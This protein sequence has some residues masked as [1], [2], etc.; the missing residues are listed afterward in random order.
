MSALVH[1][2]VQWVGC[3]CIHVC[4]MRTRPCLAILNWEEIVQV[5][6]SVMQLHITALCRI[7][8]LLAVPRA[9]AMVCDNAAAT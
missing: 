5:G 3:K 8:L 2:L 1:Q 6:E 4:I 9:F 7:Q